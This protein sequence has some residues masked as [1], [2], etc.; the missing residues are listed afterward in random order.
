MSLSADNPPPALPHSA[1]TLARAPVEPW[2]ATTAGRVVAAGVAAAC[3]AVLVT[4]STLS[5]AAE[6]HGTHTQLGLPAC[7]FYLATG[8]PCAT[9]GMTTAFAH[10]ANGSLLQ[11]FFTQPAGMLMALAAAATFWIAL[12]TALTGS[13]AGLVASR[14]LSPR[15]LIVAGIILAAA[16]AFTAWRWSLRS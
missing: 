8:Q 7:G 11:S 14:L 13:R 1:P 4:A 6:G 10:A 5:P 2:R 12:H 3:L 16:W 15:W 9:C